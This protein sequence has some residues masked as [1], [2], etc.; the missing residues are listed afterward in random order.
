MANLSQESTA[1]FNPTPAVVQ[2][3]TIVEPDSVGYDIRRKSVALVCTHGPILAESGSSFGS[4]QQ[5]G[6]IISLPHLRGIRFIEI[7][8]KID[9]GI[10]AVRW[11]D[12]VVIAR[13]LPTGIPG[14]VCQQ[15]GM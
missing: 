13:G 2:I 12:G 9:T 14:R 5:E 7:T 1:C 11:L 3:E 15:R 4:T 6:S 8:H 10:I